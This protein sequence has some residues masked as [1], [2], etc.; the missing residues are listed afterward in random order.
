VDRISHLSRLLDEERTRNRE[1]QEQILVLCEKPN[2]VPVGSNRPAKVIYMDDHR[3]LEM[4]EEGN[5]PT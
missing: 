3:L 5:G 4:E 2:I 1:L